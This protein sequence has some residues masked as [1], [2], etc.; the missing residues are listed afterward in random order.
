MTIL[1]ID[2]VIGWDVTSASFISE[3]EQCDGDVEIQINSG[4][5]AVFDGISIFNAIKNYDK[6]K[7]TIVITAFAASMA[8]Y[9]ALAGDELKAYDNATYMIHNPWTLSIGDYRQLKKDSDVCYG[10]AKILSKTYSHKSQKSQKE[11]AKL[12]D[13]ESWFYGEEIVDA[14]FADVLLKGNE[15]KPKEQALALAS[16][17]L[18]YAKDKTR[19]SSNND[20]SLVAALV[21]DTEEPKP[22]KEGVQ[23]EVVGEKNQLKVNAIKARLKL[24]GKN[25]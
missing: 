16:Q 25:I 14:G 9:I 8:S 6:G 24:K 12:M 22:L 18:A 2:G 1:K 11:I 13:E 21:A 23:E 15:D 3:L 19:E 17:A 20:I 5:G 10:L 4:G 7:V